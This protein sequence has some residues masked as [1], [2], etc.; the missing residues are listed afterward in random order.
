MNLF[1]HAVSGSSIIKQSGGY[2]SGPDHFPYPYRHKEVIK[3][4]GNGSK[5]TSNPDVMAFEDPS[6][7]VAIQQRVK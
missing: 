3:N 5:L 4:Y 2:A 6:A 1:L 7:I